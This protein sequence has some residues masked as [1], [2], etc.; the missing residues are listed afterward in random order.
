M[1]LRGP[2]TNKRKDIWDTF[3]SMFI[4]EANAGQFDND[5]GNYMLE[6]GIVTPDELDSMRTARPEM[7]KKLY[8]DYTDSLPIEIAPPP[9]RT[10]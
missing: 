1:V 10:E 9:M 6:S 3:T 4:S 5:F 7:Y 8:N 2:M